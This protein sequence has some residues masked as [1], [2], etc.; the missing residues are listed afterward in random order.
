MRWSQDGYSASEM[1][2]RTQ[3]F[4]IV[5]SLDYVIH[6]TKIAALETN[7]WSSCNF[8]E[9]RSQDN[10]GDMTG[11]SLFVSF[12]LSDVKKKSKHS[13]SPEELPHSETPPQSYFL[14]II[15]PL[16]ATREARKANTWLFQHLQGKWARR[17]GSV[18]EEASCHRCP[19]ENVRAN[20]PQRGH[21]KYLNW[22][23]GA[24]IW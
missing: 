1:L 19:S 12:L 22:G 7:T 3:V 8:T 9:N 2:S 18:G 21:T 6:G 14:W 5:S 17:R 11:L 23:R 20:V 13:I 10:Q 4:G 24:V 16:P 15:L